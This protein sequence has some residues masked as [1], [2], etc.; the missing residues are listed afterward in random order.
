MSFGRLAIPALTGRGYADKAIVD[1]P[2]IYERTSKFRGRISADLVQVRLLL[3]FRRG[4]SRIPD[5]LVF[6]LEAIHAAFGVNQLLLACEEGVA[7]GTDFYAD[8]ALVSGT[9]AELVAAG[10]DYINFFVRRVDTGFH[11]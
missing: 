2:E 1:V 4:S 3:R 6:L 11:G 8:I 7:A 5:L 10:A 9:G